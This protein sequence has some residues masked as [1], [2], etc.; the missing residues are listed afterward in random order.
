[1]VFAD[2]ERFT[3]LFANLFENS[4]RY[5]DEG[6]ELS[7][8]L[9]PGKDFVAVEF[10]D[11]KPGVP[12]EDLSRLFDR[13]YRVEGSRN[14]KTGGAGLGLAIS[15]NIVE[16]HGG[17]I[18]AHQSSQGGLLIRVTLPVEEGDRE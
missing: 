15:K 16:A 13:L 8:S 1:M 14:R 12:D 3:Q 5:T 18:S 11:S 7:V 4:L 2:Q 6:G 17:T 9:L 10:Q